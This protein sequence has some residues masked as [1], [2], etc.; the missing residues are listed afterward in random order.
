MKKFTIVTVKDGV[1]NKEVFSKH[2]DGAKYRIFNIL[3]CTEFC[4]KFDSVQIINHY[5]K[6]VHYCGTTSPYVKK[7]KNIRF[8]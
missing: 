7:H 6:T 2:D 3:N 4:K 5:S 1:S 8:K